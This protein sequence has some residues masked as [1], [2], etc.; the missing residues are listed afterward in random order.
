LKDPGSVIDVI[1]EAEKRGITS[2]AEQL[3]QIRLMR[4][5]IAHEYVRAYLAPLFEKT[6][7]LSPSLIGTMQ[8]ALN[9]KPQR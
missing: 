5:Q 6:L 9:Y 4:N 1:S 3:T 7:E 8:A 2:S